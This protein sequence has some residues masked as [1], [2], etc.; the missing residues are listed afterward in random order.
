MQEEKGPLS[1]VCSVISAIIWSG[2]ALINI[3]LLYESV[4]LYLSW[5][6]FGLAAVFLVWSIALT[7]VLIKD[8]PR[9]KQDETLILR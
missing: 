1:V 2:L 8:A 7:F 3:A 6:F 9:S 4:L 5:L